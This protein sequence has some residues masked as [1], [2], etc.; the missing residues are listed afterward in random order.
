MRGVCT[1]IFW[2]GSESVAFSI[3]ALAGSGFTAFKLSLDS[4]D[5]I[6]KLIRVK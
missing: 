2:T 6:L 4:Q 5:I 3:E 1:W